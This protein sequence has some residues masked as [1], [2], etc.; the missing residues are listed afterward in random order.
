IDISGGT[1]FPGAP[2]ASDSG[3]AGPYFAAFATE[4]RR[5]TRTPLMLTGGF[6]TRA[7][8]AEVLR[9]GTADLIGL[10][11]SMILAPDLPNRWRADPGWNPTFPRFASPPDGGITAWYTLRLTELGKDVPPQDTPDLTAA[12][13]R[14]NDRDA[15]RAETWRAQFPPT[16]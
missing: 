13:A 3:G 16:E 14:Y 5:R 10:A 2:A 4:A 6:K 1:Y 11:R 8:A 12:L 7:Q 15:A 9:D